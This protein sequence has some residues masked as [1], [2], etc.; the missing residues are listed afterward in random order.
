[1][2]GARGRDKGQG[3]V[4]GASDRGKWKGMMTGGSDRGIEK[5]LQGILQSALE[6]YLQEVE[7]GKRVKCRMCSRRVV[8]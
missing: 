4:T 1:M 7:G 2:R 5:V 3:K 6:G 8:L